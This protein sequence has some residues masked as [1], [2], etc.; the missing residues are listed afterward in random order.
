MSAVYSCVVSYNTAAA[1]GLLCLLAVLVVVGFCRQNGEFEETEHQGHEK[2]K[3]D[4][5]PLN[6]F[7]LFIAFISAT[8]IG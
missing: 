7:M 4:M 1:A 2:V 5:C 8:T 6:I 3:K